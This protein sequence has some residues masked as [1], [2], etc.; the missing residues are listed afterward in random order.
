LINECI[1]RV[2][3]AKSKD[4]L[5]EIL[6]H[7][8]EIIDKEQETCIQIAQQEISLLDDYARYKIS[9]FKIV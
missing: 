6:T 7:Y 8:K 4:E 5:R 1:E 3:S 9:T 2:K